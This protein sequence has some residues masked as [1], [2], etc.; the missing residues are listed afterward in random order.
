MTPEFI[1]IAKKSAEE[2]KNLNFSSYDK[3]Y[4]RP[5]A[6]TWSDDGYFEDSEYEIQQTAT[7]C[8]SA[9]FAGIEDSNLTFERL[10]RDICYQITQCHIGNFLYYQPHNPTYKRA[11]EHMLRLGAV[12]LYDFVHPEYTER[13]PDRGIATLWAFSLDKKDLKLIKGM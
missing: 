13:K 2:W 9:E 4:I 1:Q 10:V 12:P 7:H 6:S 11:V 8:G 5:K 3:P